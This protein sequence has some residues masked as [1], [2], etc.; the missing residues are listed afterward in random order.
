MKK[1]S[2]IFAAALII[3]LLTG[4][5]HPYQDHYNSHPKQTGQTGRTF[6][7]DLPKTLP[8][9]VISLLLTMCFT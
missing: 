6:S 2:Y 4:C 9:F 1:V 8:N 3:K 5:E 7:A